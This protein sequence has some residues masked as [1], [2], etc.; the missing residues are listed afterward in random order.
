MKLTCN[1]TSFLN[2]WSRVLLAIRQNAGLSTSA[3]ASLFKLFIQSM[4]IW[5]RLLYA[6]HHSVIYL[7]LNLITV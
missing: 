4:N 5:H 1:Q 6:Q 3:L 2:Q 7:E